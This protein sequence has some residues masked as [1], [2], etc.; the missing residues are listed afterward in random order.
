M[1]PILRMLSCA[2]LV[3]VGVGQP[4]PAQTGAPAQSPAPA[5]G[6]SYD[7]PAMHFS[8]PAG[9]ERLEL[10][11]RPSDGQPGPVAVFLKNRGK[12]DQ[13]SIVI[14]TAAFSGTLDG[15][16]SA[17]ESEI[18]S[19]QEGTFVDKK[20]RVTM[21]NGMP[22]WWLKVTTGTDVG[23]F[24]RRYEYVVFDGKRSIVVAYAGRLGDVEEK[25]AQA[26][27]AS[28]TVVLFPRGR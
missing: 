11:A 12:Y 8:A 23:K 13:K 6:P 10:A 3:Q 22:A 21:P 4:V 25:E 5:T 24:S 18:R 15:L 9:W 28:L 26:A 27:L 1:K 2:V 20:L 17:H 7:D 16:A 14:T 19:Q